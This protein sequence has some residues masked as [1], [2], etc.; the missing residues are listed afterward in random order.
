[1]QNKVQSPPQEQQPQERPKT[2]SAKGHSSG[3]AKDVILGM[4][5]ICLVSLY[6]LT[7]ITIREIREGHY[8]TNRKTK[9]TDLF[10]YIG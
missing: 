3:D 4:K 9:T 5:K 1:M 7:N 6:I 8:A 2:A 10:T